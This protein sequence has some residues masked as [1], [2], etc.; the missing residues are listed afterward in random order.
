MSEEPERVPLLD[1]TGIE[2][3]IRRMA[4]ALAEEHRDLSRLAVIGIPTRGVELARRLVRCIEEAEGVKPGFGTVDVA[5][6]RDDY[7]TRPPASPM[8]VSNLPLPLEGKELVLVDDVLFTGRTVRAALDALS[9]YGR[10]D[11]VQ[12]AVLVD[13]GH[14]ELPIQPD[15]AGTTLTTARQEKIRVRFANLDDVP[16]DGVWLVRPRSHSV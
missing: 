8:A 13:R 2:R 6:H 11:R 3:A 1:A 14:R 10:P 15:H 9:T 16:A 4:A 5:M 7:S 12:L